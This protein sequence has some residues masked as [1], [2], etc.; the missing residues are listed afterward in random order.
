MS[1]QENRRQVLYWRLL[2]RLFDPEEQAALESASVAVV[3]DLGLPTALL[4]PAVSVDNVVQRFPQLESELAGLIEHAG[5]DREGEVRRAALMSK[6]M[7]NVFGTG[8]GSVTAEQ[9]SRWQADAGWFERALDQAPGEVRRERTGL[10]PVLAGIEGDLVNRMHLREVLAD[11][12]L[13]GRLTPSMSLIAQLLRPST[14]NRSHH[15][16]STGADE[17]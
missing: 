15:V 6:L 11:S 12:K 5:D 8:S 3:D 9:L 13:A 14:T 2:A 4:D 1:G 16:G 17:R 7:L 10:G